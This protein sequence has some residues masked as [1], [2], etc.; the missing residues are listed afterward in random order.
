MELPSSI[1]TREEQQRL[2]TPHE[3]TRDAASLRYQNCVSCG[4]RTEITCIKVVI[5]IV[6]TGRESKLKRLSSETVSR[7]SM[8]HCQRPA[9]RESEITTR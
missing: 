8:Y 9:I 1:H 2:L 3:Y 4:H 5:V 7:I 6:A